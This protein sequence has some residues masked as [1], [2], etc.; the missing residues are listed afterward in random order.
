MAT[1]IL[2]PPLTETAARARAIRTAWT[3]DPDM[4]DTAGCLADAVRVLAVRAATNDAGLVA[5][6][7][8]ELAANLLVLQFPELDDVAARTGHSFVPAA[9]AGTYVPGGR[10]HRL[11]TDA[12][13]PADARHWGA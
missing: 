7:P 10:L 8:V 13:G 2:S 9:G 5:P 6:A 11:Y 1:A 12:F 3:S 4:P